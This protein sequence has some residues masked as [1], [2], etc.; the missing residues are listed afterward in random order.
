MRFRWQGYAI[1]KVNADI[2]DIWQNK[3][4]TTVKNEKKKEKKK[5]P[6]MTLP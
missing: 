6:Y 4:L 5:I 2:I 1:D 3:L